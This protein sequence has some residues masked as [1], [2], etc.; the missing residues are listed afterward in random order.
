MKLVITGGSGWLG[1]E[2]RKYFPDALMPSH[3]ELDLADA[4][5]IRNW[6]QGGAQDAVIHAAAITNA[7]RCERERTTAWTVNVIGTETLLKEAMRANPQVYFLYVSTAGVFSGDE[8]LY[9]EEAIPCPRNFYCLTKYVAEERIRSFSSVCIVRTNFVS[10][11]PWPHG[12]AFADRWGTYLFAETVAQGIKEVVDAR[13]CGVLHLCGD[14]RMSLYDVA[15][16][17]NPHVEPMTLQTYQGPPLPRDLSL[18]T[19]RWK[20]YSLVR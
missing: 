7:E 18:I 5:S 19:N 3:R 4:S 13:V 1:R 9:D 16:L 12:K 15:R 11:E 2:L 8:G 10:R 14:R 20:T 6:F 17:T